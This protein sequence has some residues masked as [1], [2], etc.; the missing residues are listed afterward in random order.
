MMETTNTYQVLPPLSDEEYQALKEDI[1]ENGVLVPVVKD[2]DGNIIDGHHRVRAYEELLA[3][4]RVAGGY[5]VV[6]RSGITNQEKRDLAWRLNMQ[7]RHLNREQKHEAIERKLKESPEW[8]DSRIAKLLGVD[9]KTV[10]LSRV[11][12]EGRKDIAKLKKLVGTDGKEY[13]RELK[14]KFKD[15]GLN[16]RFAKGLAQAAASTERPKSIPP[17]EWPIIKPAVD[18]EREQREEKG[19]PFSAE[20]RQ[21]YAK[22]VAEQK[23]ASRDAEERYRKEERKKHTAMFTEVDA[24]LSEAR[25]ELKE[26]LDAVRDVDFTE[27]EVELLERQNDAVAGMSRLFGSALMGDSETDWDAELY[28]LEQ[29]RQWGAEWEAE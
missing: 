21:G 25:L 26:A 13:P 20:E 8:A 15:M 10:R 9:G 7:R 29:R 3:E 27:E 1:A 24:R 6:E 2:T 28:K 19:V 4:D 5:P 22:R 16:P 11:M 17:N 18:R 14:N 12:L 23:K